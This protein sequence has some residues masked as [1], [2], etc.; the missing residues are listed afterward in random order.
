MDPSSRKSFDQIVLATLLAVVVTACT[1]SAS[2]PPPRPS[3]PIVG[4]D[5]SFMAEMEAGGAEWKDAQGN[6]VDLLAFCATQGVNTIRLRL[7]VDPIAGHS[8]LN[9][10]L[11]V[12]QRA[13]QAGLG[14]WL[15]VHYSDQW[16]DPG[17]QVTPAAWQGLAW[18]ELKAQVEDYTALVAQTIQP[19]ILQ[20]GNEVNAGFLFP[21]G[22]ITTTDTGFIQLMEAGLR[23]G[24]RGYPAAKTMIHYAGIAGSHYFLERIALLQPDL[25]GLSYYP[26]WHGY[27]PAV[28]LDSMVA[29]QEAFGIPIV[30]AETSYP[31]TLNW[32]DQTHNVVGLPGQLLSDYPASI[33]GQRAYLMQWAGAVKSKQLHGWCYWG[34]EWHAWKGPNSQEGSSWENQALF[35]FDGQAVAGWDAFKASLP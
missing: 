15:A 14:I 35:D 9:E 3:P 2:P 5:L 11:A 25:V 33:S 24:Q 6:P 32:N 17:Q 31:F 20:I 19:H 4:V 1:K 26:W 27:P 34:T 13:R 28:A 10:V 18:P 7:W 16:A 22:Q 12:A 21:E 23:G 8:T 29:L 30:V